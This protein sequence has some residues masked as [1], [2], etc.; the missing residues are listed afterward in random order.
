MVSE[1]QRL[2]IESRRLKVAKTILETKGRVEDISKSTSIPKSTIQRDLTSKELKE[3]IG[4]DSFFEIQ[5]ILKANKKIGLSKG[6]KKSVTNNEVL[7][8]KLGHFK[9][10]NKR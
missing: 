8:D 3:L 10:V 7:R 9:G 5:S 2:E 4:E 1:K 6:G